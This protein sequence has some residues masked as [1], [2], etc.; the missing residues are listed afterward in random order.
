MDISES[1]SKIEKS[2]N[3][4]FEK[5]NTLYISK[6]DEEEIKKALFHFRTQ[7]I[8]ALIKKLGN[9]IVSLIIL[10]NSWLIKRFDKTTQNFLKKIFS[11]VDENFFKEISQD[12]INDRIYSSIEF[13]EFIEGFNITSENS[14]NIYQDKKRKLDI[15]A[16]AFQKY[17]EDYFQ[18]NN[19]SF[20][21]N[22][23]DNEFRRFPDLYDYINRNR[24]DMLSLLFKNFEDDE[25]TAISKWIIENKISD[26]KDRIWENLLKSFEKIGFDASIEYIK[27]HAVNRDKKIIKNLIKRILGSFYKIKDFEDKIRDLYRDYPYPSIQTALIY[28]LEP[29]KFKDKKIAQN[30]IIDFETY[31]VPENTED[32]VKN[33]ENWTNKRDSFTDVEDFIS[34]LNNQDLT[35][36]KTLGYFSVRL[37][38][39][40]L[41]IILNIFSKYQN[42]DDV[43][44]IISFYLTNK[45]KF[46]KGISKKFNEITSD[47][48]CIEYISEF[49]EKYDIRTQQAKDFLSKNGKDDLLAKF[50]RR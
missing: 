38:K 8:E 5:D 13:K 20:L 45:L 39:T 12:I 33:I 35:N 41:E 10:R 46:N 17:L 9:K 18:K 23:I 15:R 28:M 43:K 14:K 11:Q 27:V 24:N 36:D 4:R 25:K 19:I 1:L 6:K 3:L 7:P 21:L 26:K 31:K 50:N 48:D 40:Q 42:N 22:F 49:I 30:L 16:K 44:K 29:D 37:E 32:A 47:K 34:N 2:L